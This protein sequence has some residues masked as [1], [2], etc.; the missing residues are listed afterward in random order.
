MPINCANLNM[1]DVNEMFTK[2]LYEFP[3]EQINLTFPQ[4]INNLDDE[5]K[6]KVELFS[7][8]KTA[9]T[10]ATLLKDIDSCVS[11]I[12]HT[13]IIE[14]TS[15]TQIQLGTG[16]VDVNITLK[17]EL[18]YNILTEM[19][20]IKINNEEDLF[21]TLISLAQSKAEFDKI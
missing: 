13:E 7:E 19:S 18:L 5:H 10:S 11:K 21:S 1:N 20:G 6:I 12:S 4:W 8:I 14:K 15:I 17:E 16:S 9:F 2:V 3:I